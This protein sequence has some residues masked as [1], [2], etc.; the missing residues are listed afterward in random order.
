MIGQALAVFSVYLP[1]VISVEL[2]L[3]E[4]SLTSTSPQDRL[5]LAA[6]KDRSQ[7]TGAAHSQRRFRHGSNGSTLKTSTG[8]LQ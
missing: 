2:R 7:C 6:C 8:G 1:V 5:L 4:G 3:V